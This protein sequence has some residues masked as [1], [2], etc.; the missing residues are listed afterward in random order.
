MKKL[1]IV[2]VGTL[3]LAGCMTGGMNA[4][5]RDSGARATMTY[6][7]G[8]SQDNF[9]IT[10]PE[11]ETF[12][13]KGVMVGKSTTIGNTFA[14]GTMTGTST[15][16]GPGGVVHGTHSGSG[17]GSAF[18]V[19]S[20]Y[21]GNVAAVLFGDKGHTM[22]CSFQYADTSGLTNLGGVGLC[23]TSDGRVLDVQW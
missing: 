23:E 3:G 20:S 19:V 21:T 12:R 14:S 16:F 5:I 6:E 11:G 18:S 10:L 7:Q 17:R 4:M 8:M 1:W 22:R 2:L 15:Y 9:T 13:G